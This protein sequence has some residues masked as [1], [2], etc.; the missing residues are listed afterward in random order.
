MAKKKVEKKE[1]LA[2]MSA[3]ELEAQLKELNESYFRMRFRHSTSPLKNPMEIRQARRSIARV[4][5][6]LRQKEVR[7]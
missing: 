5:T 1:D 7:V 3:A 2:T 4:K 6:L